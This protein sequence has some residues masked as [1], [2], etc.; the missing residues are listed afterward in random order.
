[1]R[2]AANDDQIILELPAGHP[3]HDSI[4]ETVPGALWN[5][6]TPR[7]EFPA[8]RRVA[9]HLRE[10]LRGRSR[11]LSLDP[12]SARKLASLADSA[13]Q[14]D[15]V[16]E[17][18]LPVLRIEFHVEYQNFAK[19][20][21]GQRQDDQSWVF[22]ESSAPELIADIN[23]RS[24]D[25]QISPEVARLAGSAFD[26]PAGYDGT[27][28]SLSHIPISV[29]SAA[30]KKQKSSLVPKKPKRGAKKPPKQPKSFLDRLSDL[31]LVS[32]FDLINY[33]PLRYIDR[34]T[35]SRIADMEIGQEATLIATITS[36]TPY[37]P[38]KRHTKLTIQDE[39]GKTMHVSFFNQ[40]YINHAYHVGDKV[41]LHGKCTT[42]TN[43]RG[44]TFKQLDSPSIDRLDSRRGSRKVIP[45]YPQSEKAGI[46]TW[47]I[48]MLTDE[49]LTRISS[50]P[51]MES[52][53]AELRKKYGIVERDVA[54]HSIHLPANLEEA[55]QAKR[56]LVY[57]ELL[58]LQLFIQSR[59]RATEKMPGI[60]HSASESSLVTDYINSL[61]YALTGAQ[62]RAKQEILDDMAKPVPMHRLLQGDVGS[63]KSSIAALTVLNSVSSGYQA[64]LMAPTEIL[65]E[66][67]Y[68]GLASDLEK[69]NAISPRTGEPLRVE[70]LGGKTTKKN[71]E[72]ITQ[73]LAQG[74]IDIVVGTHALISQGVEFANLGVAVIDEQHRFGTKQRTTLRAARP[75]GKVPDML[76]M[77]ATPIPRTGAMVTYG[78][79]DI[80]ILDELPP[81]RVPIDTFWIKESGADLVKK[82]NS[83]V[84]DDIRREVKSGRQAY[85]VA[86]L[87]EDN[88]KL[89]A[90]S[91]EDALQA[92]Q[93][94]AL[95]D[96]TLGMVHGRMPRKEREATMASFANGDIDVLVS[97]TV[98]EVGV[99]VPNATVMV[100]LDAGKFGIAQLHQIRGRVGRSSY[101]SRCYLVSDTHTDDGVA[102]L[103]AL[104]QST[105]GFFL[106]ERD[107][108]IRGEGALFGQRQ[109]G[110]SDLRI[111]SLRNMGALTA[112]KADA[113]SLISSD[114]DLTHYPI[115][116]DEAARF[117]SDKE[118]QS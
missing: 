25:I 64:A 94:G 52:L 11:D 65:A 1:M 82:Q 5:S 71:K 3:L 102:R 56:R 46:T 67:L 54:F 18:G 70:F 50:I 113:E 87:V 83:P 38:H 74:E 89:A 6:K 39:D 111:A 16:L 109:S 99:N 22:D 96:L 49:L 104:V 27:L 7:W 21:N 36:M 30:Q 31:G 10:L 62:A 116:R 77:T 14:Y 61:P 101:A 57:E 12:A 84:W 79:L 98:I 115:L 105:D 8:T 29:L 114:P 53:P 51:L 117:F 33:M 88:E 35:P 23:A 91:T 80:T 108:E 73:A 19:R 68:N 90:Q 92:L 37:N 55:H 45:I 72:I 95:F 86:S 41:I 78:D 40:R 85:V 28:L 103:D 32:L 9:Q 24:L 43:R 60:S 44:Q 2:L 4:R 118:I 58:S 63:G 20:H 34:S 100:I 81:G 66:Q 106:A 17:Q 42:W 15:L 76:V 75:D 97:T 93:S 69:M 26:A 107:L 48:L 110:E 47:D 112:A 59:K 13:P